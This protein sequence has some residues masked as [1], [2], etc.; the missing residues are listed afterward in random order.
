MIRPTLFEKGWR[1]IIPV[2]SYEASLFSKHAGIIFVIYNE[3]VIR[4][5]NGMSYD[6]V[7]LIFIVRAAY[8]LQI[9]ENVF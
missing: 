1:H 9:S 6:I 7:K 3:T 8:H 5:K 2:K 4:L